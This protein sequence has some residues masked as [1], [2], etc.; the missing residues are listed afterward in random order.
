MREKTKRTTRKNNMRNNTN[1]NER[2]AQWGEKHAKKQTR[3]EKTTTD[4]QK[5]T[6]P[7][8]TDIPRRRKKKAEGGNEQTK[9]YNIA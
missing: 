9:S 4:T 5:H 3:G 7:K 6:S 8:N 1:R 2:P